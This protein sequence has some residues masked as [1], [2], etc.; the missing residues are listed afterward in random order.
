M[1][2]RQAIDKYIASRDNL[3][4]PATIRGYI[5]IRNTR[6]K[7]AMDKRLK[8]IDDW[9]SICNNEC[10]QNGIG[11][12]PKTLINSWRFI[13][14]VMRYQKVEVPELTLPQL[15]KKNQ[16]WIEPEDIHKFLN[17]IEGDTCE[18]QILLTMHGLRA[19]EVRAVVADKNKI[20][21]KRNNITV[22]GAVVLNKEGKYVKKETNKNTSSQR[23][24]PI[25]IPRL[26]T[27]AKDADDIPV[28]QSQAVRN[29]INNA[30]EKIGVAPVGAQGLRRS[31]ASL[32]YHLKLSER[33]TMELGGW[34]DANTMRKIYIDLAKRD[35]HKATRKLSEFF[36]N[37]NENANDKSNNSTE[38][39][40]FPSPAPSV[41]EPLQ[42]QRFLLCV[43]ACTRFL[44]DLFN[45]YA[46]LART[47][48]A[49]L[50]R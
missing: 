8:D 29:H 31:F 34:S 7:S 1:T 19:S 45:I 42:M 44:L 12:S 21:L 38:L 46:I 20:D 36:N 40:R 32:C 43:I 3:L 26:V 13:C 39:L 17:A 14:A 27:L 24:V 4:S 5:A 23:I 41:L 28:Y 50:H 37:A 15:V 6:F 47:F 9:Q 18:F 22:S 2:L 49:L 25:L 10:K 16:P 30:C 48:T 33:E 11:V 35:K